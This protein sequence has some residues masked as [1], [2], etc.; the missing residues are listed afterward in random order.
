[1]KE[2]IEYEKCKECDGRGSGDFIDIEDYYPCPMCEGTGEVE[3]GTKTWL[4]KLLTHKE[5]PH[6]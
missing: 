1:M 5:H 3:K 2:K 6:T 4:E